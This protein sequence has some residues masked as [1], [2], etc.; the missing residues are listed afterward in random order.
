MLMR[1]KQ[2]RQGKAHQGRGTNDKTKVRLICDV[3][4]LTEPLWTFAKPYDIGAEKLTT[5]RTMRK[6]FPANDRLEITLCHQQF[7]SSKRRANRGGFDSFLIVTIIGRANNIMKPSV[8]L[9]QLC[10]R[11]LAKLGFCLFHC[12][13]TQPIHILGYMSELCLR[14]DL[15]P[16]A[17]DRQTG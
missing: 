17:W 11:G 6:I 15:L 7:R 13:P 1:P 16:D 3:H 2:Q 10:V 12:F 4:D 5:C 8:H 9:D 14:C